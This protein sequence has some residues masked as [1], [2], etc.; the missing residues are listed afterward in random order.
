[1]EVLISGRRNAVLAEGWCLEAG[2]PGQN[3]DVREVYKVMNKFKES[4]KANLTINIFKK[5]NHDLNCE[6]IIQN[7]E[8]PE[9]IKAVFDAA[10]LMKTE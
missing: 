3:A 8:I 10:E 6:E 4:G 9:G 5:H 2:T 1:M 7:G